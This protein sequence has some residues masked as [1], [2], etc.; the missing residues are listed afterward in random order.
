MLCPSTFEYAMESMDALTNY[1]H[2]NTILEEDTSS[3]ITI[4]KLSYFEVFLHFNS[5]GCIA[6][7]L[8]RHHHTI[9]PLSSCA[10]LDLSLM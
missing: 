5:V 1:G 2:S 3:E 4:P 7:C 6:A 10:I 8:G 9:L